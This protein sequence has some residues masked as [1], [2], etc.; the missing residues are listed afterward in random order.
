MPSSPANPS[1]SKPG[2]QS[3]LQLSRFTVTAACSSDVAR[4]TR[5]QNKD[6]DVCVHRVGINSC[7]SEAGTSLVSVTQ[8]AA[9]W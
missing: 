1:Q 4:F 5:L 6:T 9:L 7:E 3:K 2:S 8:S